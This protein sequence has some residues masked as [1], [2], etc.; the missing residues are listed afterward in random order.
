MKKVFALVSLLVLAAAC[1]GPATNTAPTANKAA[2]S[3]A[4]PR[5]A[6]DEAAAREKAAWDALKKKDYEAFGNLLASDQLQITSEAVY[7][8]AGSINGV[9]GWEPTDVTFS[10]WKVLSIDKD[11]VLVTYTVNVKGSSNGK[12]LPPETERASSAWVNRSG[13]WQAIYH[14]DCVVDTTPP[15]PPPRPTPPPAGS[16]P[17]KAAAPAA[18]AAAAAPG[19]DAATDEKMVWDA[20]KSRN[21]E[22]FGSFL[23]A[24][25]IEVEPEAVYD[26]AG[27]VKAVSEFDFSQTSLSDWKVVKLNNDASLVT[28]TIKVPGAT[29]MEARHST[30]WVNRG[31]K[32]SAIF[33]Q[34]TP[35]KAPEKAAPLAKL[36]K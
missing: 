13:K 29:P 33:H 5:M 28:Y 34:G 27:S 3:K 21:Y 18:K 2:E 26:K 24:D 35:V 20:L 36:P 30:I 17:P 10:D 19:P 8:K 23:T 11:A 14:Q 16:Q 1:G 22:A 25:F 4:A 12:P 7:D 15:P 6:D 32:W 9:K 31:G